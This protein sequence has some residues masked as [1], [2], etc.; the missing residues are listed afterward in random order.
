ME[1]KMRKYCVNVCTLCNMPVLLCT[2][3]QMTNRRKRQKKRNGKRIST[4]ANGTLH[5][6][7]ESVGIVSEL[8]RHFSDKKKSLKCYGL[9]MTGRQAGGY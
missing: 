8:H 2:P 5:A 7:S 9:V 1:S 3:A 6:I 4:K